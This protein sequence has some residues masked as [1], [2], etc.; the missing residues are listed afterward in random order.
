MTQTLLPKLGG[1]LVPAAEV[2]MVGYG[3]RQRPQE[4]AAAPSNQEIH[5]P[6]GNRAPSRWNV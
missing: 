4:R 6:R 2:L 1:S 5:D 3:A